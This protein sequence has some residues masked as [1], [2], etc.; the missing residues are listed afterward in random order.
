MRVAS[1]TMI[2]V[3]LCA[4]RTPTARAQ[5]DQASFAKRVTKYAT[6]DTNK[7][8]GLCWCKDGFGGTGMGEAGYVVEQVTSGQVLVGCQIPEFNGGQPAGF[9][10]CVVEWDM[11]G[12]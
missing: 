1:V 8:K 3:A 10:P 12:K 4:A 9:A 11:L 5:E 7:P 6:V 2:V